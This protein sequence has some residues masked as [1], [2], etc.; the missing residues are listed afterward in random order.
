MK[1]VVAVALGAFL[2]SGCVAPS[3]VT[4]KA[5]LPVFPQAEYQNLK[6]KGSNT[7]TGQAF[8]MTMGG[9]TKVAAG[10]TVVLSPKTSY[11]DVMYTYMLS[12]TASADPDPRVFQY[13]KTTQADAEGRFKFSGVAA[14]QY[15]VRTIVKWF[16]PSRYG[17]MP[18]GGLV[19][20]PTTVVDDQENTVMVTQ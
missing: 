20:V 18:E 7:L 2:L 11:S 15:Y 10:Q 4:Q 16:R 3:M 1:K 13:D 6:T 14:G 19:V 9:D 8:L 5:N 17:L 12:G